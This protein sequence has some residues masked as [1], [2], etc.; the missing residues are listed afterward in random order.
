MKNR[1]D[2]GNNSSADVFVSVHLNIINEKQ[3]WGWQTFYYKDNGKELA[4]SIQNGLNTSIQKTNKRLPLKISNKYILENVKIPATIVE[5][6]FLSNVEEAS[7]LNTDEYQSKI[8][9]GIYLGVIN[10]F[11]S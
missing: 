6:G 11:S 10:Y 3:Y 5:C 7:L 4:T 2:I 1:V 8:A 9:W